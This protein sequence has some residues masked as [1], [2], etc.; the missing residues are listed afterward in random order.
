[1]AILFSL[2]I[3]FIA[4]LLNLR[5]NEFSLSFHIILLFTIGAIVSYF[6]CT[7]GRRKP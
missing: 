6:F 7:L 2:T 1:M 3:N 4:L 5:S